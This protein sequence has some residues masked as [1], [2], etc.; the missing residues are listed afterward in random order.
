MCI[1][2]VITRHYQYWAAKNTEYAANTVRLNHHL[3]DCIEVSR[4]HTWLQG[5]RTKNMHLVAES[6][7]NHT[8]EDG[9]YIK[10]FFPCICMKLFKCGQNIVMW[11][12]KGP[13]Q[14][15]HKSLI[16][17]VLYPTMHQS[18]QKCAHFVLELCIVGYGRDALWILWYWSV[19]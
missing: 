3:G 15:I 16:A 9:K 12:K 19:G 4:P 14:L 6:G 11:F 5:L 2:V 1:N 13:I 17:S 7:S 18:E 8:L 10:N